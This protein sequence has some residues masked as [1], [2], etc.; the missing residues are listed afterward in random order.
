[1]CCQPN[2]HKHPFENFANCQCHEG[3]TLSRHFVTKT[4]K[5]NMLEK[6][7]EELTKELSGV[8]EHI[9]TLKSK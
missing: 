3:E 5:I 6:Y 1:M 4:E 2:P 8:E 7:K 9:S